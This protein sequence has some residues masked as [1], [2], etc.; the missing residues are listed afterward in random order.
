[1][2]DLREKPVYNYFANAGVYLLRSDLLGEIAPDTYLDAPDFIQ[3]LIDS[4]RKVSYFPIEGTWID[5]GSPEDY[6]R[7]DELMSR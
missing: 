4:G 1:M 7:A 5:I 6:R 2:R 3:G